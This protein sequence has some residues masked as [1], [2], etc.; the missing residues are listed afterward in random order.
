L[1]KN[2]DVE[3]V[4]SGGW[5]IVGPLSSFITYPSTIVNVDFADFPNAKSKAFEARSEG[6]PITLSFSF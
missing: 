2:V 1:S 5:Y 3:K 6:F 4:Y